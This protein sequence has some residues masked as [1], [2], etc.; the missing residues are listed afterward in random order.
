MGDE[1]E[2]WYADATRLLIQLS[3]PVM[4]RVEPIEI[5]VPVYGAVEKVRRCV[6]SVFRYSSEPYQLVLVD[7]GNSDL[8][9]KEYLKEL[10]L[11]RQVIVVRNE[12][13]EGFVRSVNH[14]LRATVH[15]VVIL[16]SDTEVTSRWLE[17]L[18][19]C[20]YSRPRIGT[21]TPFSNN[22]TICS[23]PDGTP[24]KDLP[25]GFT[26]D[27]FSQLVESVSAKAVAPIPTAI[28]CCMFIKRETIDSVGFFDE[29]FSPGYGEETDFCM[30]AFKAGYVNVLDASTFVYHEGSVSFSEYVGDRL[31][32]SHQTL[33]Y[34]KHP[35]YRPIVEGFLRANPLREMYVRIRNAMADHY[36]W[37]RRKVLYVLHSTPFGTNL[38]GT[39]MHTSLL[40]TNLPNY[41]TFMLFPRSGKIV[42]EELNPAGSATFEYPLPLAPDG[43]FL[44]TELI[45]VFRR[46]LAEFRIDIVHFQ[47][48]LGLSLRLP[49]EA[50]MMGLKVMLSCHDYYYICRQYTLLE[51][52]V[53]FCYACE[54]LQRC[55]LCLQK[56][57][58]YPDGFQ[59]EWRRLCKELLETV[60]LLI[61]PSTS[62]YEYY[63]KIYGCLDDKAK[64]IEHVVPMA[65]YEDFDAFRE[66]TSE[67]PLKVALAGEV[68]APSKGRNVVVDLLHMCGKDEIEWHFFGRGSDLGA[69]EPEV[70]QKAVFHGEYADGTLPL[71]LK[72]AGI[73]VAVL[74]FIWAETFSL[75]LTEIW[76]AGV[77]VIVPDLGAP[78]ERTIRYDAG[79]VYDW[80]RGAMAIKEMLD[81]IMLDPSTYS[82]KVQ[83]VRK[84]PKAHFEEWVVQYKRLYDQLSDHSVDGMMRVNS[85]FLT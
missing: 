44:D 15:D 27:T 4:F 33:V 74:P 79:W 72:Q 10:S 50:K 30:R 61:F 76:Q 2:R 84:I 58:G 59:A 19:E 39:E 51:N 23:L 32:D 67:R 48:L 65:E 64:I 28:G 35:E 29:I 56:Q 25:E 42:L 70:R 31:R 13:T 5:I 82:I 40:A 16:N 49:K 12:K 71:L 78:A 17:K 37:N 55:D 14:G 63:K 7:D 53:K 11:N 73:E 36:R 68:F 22:A 34:E 3:R 57:F 47:H 85:E 24:Q 9:L 62:A 18:H 60:D 1:Y 81:A 52:G 26:L 21:V 69:L 8:R 41:L 45:A 80:K 54:D 38:G 75:I 66:T 20:A 46:I 83:N 77:P 6:E 43:R